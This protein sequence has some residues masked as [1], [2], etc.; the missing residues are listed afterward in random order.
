MVE[1][2]GQKMSKSLGNL[3]MVRD[4][5]QEFSPDTLRLYLASH[6]YGSPWSYQLS[7][8]RQSMALAEKLRQAAMV[9][10]ANRRELDPTPSR[11]AF[12][13]SLDHDL[14]TPEGI[15]VLEKLADQILAGAAD[16]QGVRQAQATLRQLAA[17]FGLRLT[18][19]NPEPRVQ[20]G[21]LTHRHHF[22]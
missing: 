5:L 8:L 22:R 7:S 13:Q 9:E 20:Q 15:A 10:G 11:C 3:V 12:A 16:D 21:W 2:D 19:D 17:V 14:D 1:Y 6:H 4:L 18:D